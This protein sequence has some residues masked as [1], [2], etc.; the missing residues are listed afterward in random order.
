MTSSTTTTDVLII[1]GGPAGSLLACL[2]ARRG[3]KVMLAEK[4]VDLERSFRGETIAARSVLTLKQLGFEA[5]LKSHGYV[6]LTGIALWEKGNRIVHVDYRR[7]DIDA[8]PIDIPQPALIGAFLDAARGHE[9]F[10]FLAGTNFVELIEEG[11]TVRGAVLKQ[12][13]GS[14]LQVR[15]RLVVGADGRFSK[16][17]KASGLA[18]KL[19]PM[20]R[21]FLWFKL[22]RPASWGLE[23]QLVVEKDRHLVILPTFPDLLRVGYNLPKDGLAEM[24]KIGIEAFKSSVCQ[25]DPRLAP[26]VNEHIQTWGDTSFLEIFTAEMDQWARDGLLLIGDASHTATPIL[27]QGVNLALQDS[28][29]L[30]SVIASSLKKLGPDDVIRA[31]ELQDFVE[32]RRTHKSMVTRF[33]RLQEKSLSQH[34]PLNTLIRRARLKALDLFPLK[35]RLLNRVLNAPHEMEQEVHHASAR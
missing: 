26:L 12:K 20:E 27:G 5:A 25:L 9:A 17:R 35:Y 22:P 18:V 29:F 30:T 34:K 11:G 7:F 28:V 15:A 16:V 10:T 19:E 1:G 14:S 21:D 13:D 4:Q 8:V 24:R 2:L 3:I 6:E 31:S 23:G 33:Q 32:A